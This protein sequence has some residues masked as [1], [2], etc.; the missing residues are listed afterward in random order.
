MPNPSSWAAQSERYARRDRAKARAKKVTEKDIEKAI[1]QAF[2]LQHRLSLC[3]TDAGGQGVK[4]LHAAPPG[5]LLEALGIPALPFGLLPAL[6]IPPGFPDL[7][8][9]LPDGRWVF[10]EVKK[11]GGTF[12]E[13]Q[14]VFL[15][16]R[17]ME[18]HIAFHAR[19][20]DEALAKFLE[21]T[22]RSA[23]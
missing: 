7:T 9:R 23:A 21:P 5:W 18:G 8:G 17:R 1:V 2:K 19:S 10:I 11:P 16:A 6:L 15:E 22:G 14:K 3:K 4:G 20:V 12:R 13:G